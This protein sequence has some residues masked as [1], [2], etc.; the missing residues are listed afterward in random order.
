[1]VKISFTGHRKFGD[2][3][4][5]SAHEKS[6]RIRLQ[7]KLNE[8]KYTSD[9]IIFVTGAALGVDFWAAEVA[10]LLDVKLHLYLPFPREI[11]IKAAK[12]SPL[13]ISTL[14]RHIKHA[15]KVVVV[16]ETFSTQGYGER[17]RAL[18]DNSDI[19]FSYYSR[20]RSGTGHC[21]RYYVN[22]HKRPVFNLKSNQYDSAGLIVQ[23]N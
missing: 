23:N 20:A 11:Q 7:A 18:V 10:Y 17:N 21:V 9:G 22:K 12:M 16:N 19:L 14:D 15:E 3:I 6:F 8:L 13:Q 2:K 4:S 5:F 1:M